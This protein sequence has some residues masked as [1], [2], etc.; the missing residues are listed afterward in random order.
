MKSK[1]L[2]MLWG[3]VCLV[4]V[5]V[6]LSF[7]ACVEPEPTPTP[8]P[9]PTVVSEDLVVTPRFPETEPSK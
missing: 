5:L 3:S 1:R 9:T 6:A 2:I 7:M 4:L 8:T